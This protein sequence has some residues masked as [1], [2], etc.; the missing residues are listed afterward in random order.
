MEETRFPIFIC[1]FAASMA[2]YFSLSFEPSVWMTGSLFIGFGLA[3]LLAVYFRRGMAFLILSFSMMAVGGFVLLVLYDG[4]LRWLALAPIGAAL[5]FIGKAEKPDLHM[6]GRDLIMVRSAEHGLLELRRRGWVY[7]RQQIEL[8]HGQEASEI[9]CSQSCSLTLVSGA[10]LTYHNR[11]N[12]L[13]ASCRASD[14]VIMPFYEAR[15]PCKAHLYDKS[16]F[17]TYRLRQI[18]FRNGEW[19]EQKPPSNRPWHM[20]FADE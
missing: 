17:A 15:Y 5:L 19:V 1:C 9:A 13:S 3:A 2:V 4:R 14:I 16:D 7:E 6:F 11:P 10:R 12:G 18:V 8:F 20:R